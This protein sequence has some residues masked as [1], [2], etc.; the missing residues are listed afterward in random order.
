MTMTKSDW[1]FEI[2]MGF[3]KEIAG[4]GNCVA[5]NAMMLV[6]VVIDRRLEV[7]IGWFCSV[8][9]GGRSDAMKKRIVRFFND[10]EEQES[11]CKWW[12]VG[13]KVEGG[14]ERWWK[15]KDISHAEGIQKW[16]KEGASVEY[17][18]RRRNN[19][20]TFNNNLGKVLNGNNYNFRTLEHSLT[21]SSILCNARDTASGSSCRS[22]PTASNREPS[23]RRGAR[24]GSRAPSR[25]SRRP[26]REVEP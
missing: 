10:G 4:R 24:G 19:N 8:D 16:K 7:A 21:Y 11:C 1:S 9:G 20:N 25:L 12:M 14:E 23:L 17:K 2:E 3:G 13:E 22:D 5:S 15:R 26:A 18:R 6:V